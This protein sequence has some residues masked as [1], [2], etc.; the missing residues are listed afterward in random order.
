MGADGYSVRRGW[1]RIV[2]LLPLC[3]LVRTIFR[4]NAKCTG[5]RF[6]LV[7]DILKRQRQIC[8]RRHSNRRTALYD[9]LQRAKVARLCRRI[10]EAARDDARR[11]DKTLRTKTAR[12][13]HK[14]RSRR[15]TLR[16]RLRRHSRPARRMAMARTSSARSKGSRSRYRL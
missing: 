3:A 14:L 13:R 1:K 16:R 7:H 12:R 5:S 9:R 8:F 10:E 11:E 2:L 6:F 15:G 4:A